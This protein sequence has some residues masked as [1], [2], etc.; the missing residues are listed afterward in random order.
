MENERKLLRSER[1]VFWEALIIAV[2]IFSL[3][4][5]LGVFLENWRKGNIEALYSESELKL[6]DLEIQSQILGFKDFSCENAIKENIEF[7]DRIFEEAILL[8]QLEESQTLTE[9]L[10]MQHK[11]YDLLRTLFWINS[12]KIK[13]RCKNPFHTVVYLYKNAPDIDTR[14]KQ[15]AFSKTLSEL[16]DNV[17]NK[18]VL[19]PIAGN[20]NLTSTES[21]MKEYNIE[22]LPVV[23]VDEKYRVYEIEELPK[24]ESLIK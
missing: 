3:G 19:I 24:I 6:L 12:I 13:E 20:M 16:K 23:I 11:K 10:T 8:Q 7:G 2:F 9:A 14:A 17:G 18:I 15:N 5:L 22:K 4:I 1:H 21:L